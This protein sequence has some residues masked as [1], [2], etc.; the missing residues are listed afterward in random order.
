MARW[1]YLL[2]GVAVFAI[3]GIVLLYANQFGWVL[4]GVQNNWGIFGS[5]FGGVV[6]PVVSILSVAVLVVTV[7]FQGRQLTEQQFYTN[8]FQLLTL[9]RSQAEKFK[10]ESGSD[11]AKRGLDLFKALVEKLEG[12]ISDRCV[13]E[14]YRKWGKSVGD[15]PHYYAYLTATTNLLGFVCYSKVSD[16]LKKN[17]FTTISG[18]L[19]REELT[20]FLFEITLSDKHCWI[21][22]EAQEQEFFKYSNTLIMSASELWKL[23]PLKESR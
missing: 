14:G 9:H 18:N 17:A 21:R 16:D 22:K 8:L 3:F 10:L 15:D 7:F 19:S 1:I 12:A 6:G 23:F 11:N 2:A 13:W 5:Y 20:L 4:S